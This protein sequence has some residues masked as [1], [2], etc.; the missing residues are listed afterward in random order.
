MNS[1]GLQHGDFVRDPLSTVYNEFTGMDEYELRQID[2]I[3][4][5]TVF[6]TDGGCMGADEIRE[7]Y[8]E[9]EIS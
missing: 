2:R 5:S 8:L 6:M 7:V 3:E 4:G 1:K 9:S